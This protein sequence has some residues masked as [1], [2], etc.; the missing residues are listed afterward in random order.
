MFLLLK[1][2]YYFVEF[3]YRKP[4]PDKNLLFTFYAITATKYFLSDFMVALFT[5]LINITFHTQF[6]FKFCALGI[7]IYGF[8]VDWLV[9]MVIKEQSLWTVDRYNKGAIAVRKWKCMCSF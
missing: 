4:E 2:L 1:S 3:K 9:I 6:V 8:Y 7:A 5:Q